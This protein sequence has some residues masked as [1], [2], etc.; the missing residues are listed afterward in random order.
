MTEVKSA[1]SSLQPGKS[2][3]PDGFSAEFFQILH[4]KLGGYMLR[5][6][7]KAFDESS[8]SYVMNT[9][10]ISL[11]LKKGKDPEQCGSYRP[12]SLLNVDIKILAK[13]LAKRL[14]SII[15]N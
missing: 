15:P 4:D 5:A 12:I 6:F 7:S 8:V 11:I 10:I 14:E 2:S 1:I 9:A 3:G 13:M